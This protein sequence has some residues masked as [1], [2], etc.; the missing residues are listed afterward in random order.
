MRWRD[1]VREPKLRGWVG[2][3]VHRHQRVIWIDERRCI[4]E[5]IRGCRRRCIL[6]NRQD[7]KLRD[8]G[9]GDAS[10]CGHLGGWLDE[11]MFA[12]LFVEKCS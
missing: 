2:W 1:A 10:I 7:V 3:D 4:G 11:Y 5:G 6:G 8:E 9:D 12:V